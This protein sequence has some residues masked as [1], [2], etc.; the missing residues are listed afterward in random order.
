LSDEKYIPYAQRASTSI[1]ARDLFGVIV[2]VIGLAL[3]LWGLYTLFY[4]L[5][6]VVLGYP[7]GGFGVFNVLIFG[8][9]MAAVGV[10][11]LKGEW[12]VR[13]A[14]GRDDRT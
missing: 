8:I 12:L 14:Y 1:T 2:R 10:C 13:F 7:R 4:T 3:T 5:G 11:L 6:M 9:G